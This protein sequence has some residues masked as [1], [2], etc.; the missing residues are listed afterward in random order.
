MQKKTTPEEGRS[1]LPASRLF[2][3][4]G[5]DLDRVGRPVGETLGS[6]SGDFDITVEL[7]S[8]VD[9]SVSFDAFDPELH[10]VSPVLCPTPEWGRRIATS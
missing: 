10:F 8:E 6:G 9:R 1:F 4:D 3:E 7:A 5:A 2:P